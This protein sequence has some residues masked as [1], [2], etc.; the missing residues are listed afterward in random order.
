[1]Y[2]TGSNRQDETQPPSSPHRRIPTVIE[3]LKVL[4]ECS[5]W[6]SL[7]NGP[8]W[9]CLYLDLLPECHPGASFCGWLC[10]GLDAAD[11]WHSEDAVLLHLLG[12]DSHE[13]VQ[14]VGAS[15]CLQTMLS[16][17][18]LQQG[19]FGHCLCTTSLHGLLHRRQHGSQRNED[20]DE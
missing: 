17:N 8:G 2:K 10:P 14:D 13:A 20:A 15:F 16:C 6:E 1:M 3:A 5:N 18:G 9:L 7:H 19:T 11:A 12:T 4:L